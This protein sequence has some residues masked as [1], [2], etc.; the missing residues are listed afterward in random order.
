MSE[1]ANQR[2][3]P[4]LWRLDGSGMLCGSA[5]QAAQPVR[6]EMLPFSGG[7]YRGLLIHMLIACVR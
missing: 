7:F 1:M 2:C 4:G 3:F 5:L 6:E